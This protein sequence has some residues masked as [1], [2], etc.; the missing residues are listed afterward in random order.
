MELILQI[1]QN[2]RTTKDWGTSDL[3]RDELKSLSIQVK[4]TKEGPVW[5][6]ED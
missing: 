6:V 3:I 4:D 1:R 2:A 5:S